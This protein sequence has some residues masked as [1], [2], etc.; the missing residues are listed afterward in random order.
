MATKFFEHFLY[1]AEAMTDI[2]GDGIGLWDEQDQ[3]FYDVLRPAGRRERAAARPLDGR[4]DPAVRGG[5]A[6]TATSRR[7]LPEFATRLRWF[8]DH[9]PDLASLVSRWNEPGS[10]R[11]PAAVAAA[12]PSH[13]GL[14]RRMLDETEFLSD[15]GVRAL[16]KYHEAHPFV[17][18]HGGRPYSDRLRA[19]RIELR[20]CSAATRTGAARSGCRSTTC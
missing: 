2:G 1:I 8:L 6:R 14:L 20:R 12:R 13:E 5:G 15:H 19:G 4:A 16:S 9:R 10:G 7:R 3:F 11:T 18:E 17:L